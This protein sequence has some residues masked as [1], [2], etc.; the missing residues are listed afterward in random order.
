MTQISTI[1]RQTEYA[2]MSAQTKRF[3]LGVEE[4]MKKEGLL[5]QDAKLRE[6]ASA[7]LKERHDR[8]VENGTSELVQ[9]RTLRVKPEL[10]GVQR[11]ADQI[12]AIFTDDPNNAPALSSHR[13]TAQ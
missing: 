11:V 3:A 2:P 9:D 10:P 6:K 13:V 5:L 4:N 1:A 7:A 8:K 12:A